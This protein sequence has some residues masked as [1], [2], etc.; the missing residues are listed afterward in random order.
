MTLLKAQIHLE[1]H[2]ELDCSPCIRKSSDRYHLWQYPCGIATPV[3]ID[4]PPINVDDITVIISSLQL[5]S[6]DPCIPFHNRHRNHE[7]W[8]LKR[9][10]HPPS[11]SPSICRILPYPQTDAMSEPCRSIQSNMSSINSLTS[12]S[13]KMLGRPRVSVILV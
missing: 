2:P 13:S 5:P 6:E 11:G 1:N 9:V 8:I 3:I 12:P 7:Y 10:Y 4:V